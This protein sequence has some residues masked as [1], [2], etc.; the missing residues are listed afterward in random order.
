MSYM[1]TR[2]QATT[3]NLSS[4]DTSKVTNISNMFGETTLDYLDISTFDHYETNIFRIPWHRYENKPTTLK[5][6]PG[7]DVSYFDTSE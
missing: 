2:S 6:A 1:F 7:Y 3:L 4:F 5:L